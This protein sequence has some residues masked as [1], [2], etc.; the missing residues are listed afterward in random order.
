[1]SVFSLTL[2]VAMCASSFS[3]LN[4]MEFQEED[5]YKPQTCTAVN[6]NGESYEKAV[7][8]LVY[9][10]GPCDTLVKCK[11]KEEIVD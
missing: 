3:Q 5:R 11:D 4:A 9:L 1:M 10:N 8:E 2:L 7:C 6:E